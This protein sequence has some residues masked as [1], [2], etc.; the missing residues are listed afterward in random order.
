MTAL[1]TREAKDNWCMQVEQELGCSTEQREDGLPP[2][3][4]R[5]RKLENDILNVVSL[6]SVSLLGTKYLLRL[7]R[8]LCLRYMSSLV[9]SLQIHA[10]L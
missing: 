1:G 7:S 2:G 6:Q 5:V 9:L 10:T 4:V 3:L 8:L